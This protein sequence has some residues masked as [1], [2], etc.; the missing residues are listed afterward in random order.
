MAGVEGEEEG[1]LTVEVDGE[2]ASS[3][4]LR[5][6][7]EL[8][9]ATA[10]VVRSALLTVH[11]AGPEQVTFDMSEV[12]FMDSSGLSVLLEAAAKVSV[13]VAAP[14]A[15]VRRVIETT[16]LTDVLKVQQ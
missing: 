10:D 16:G 7:G 6:A 11:G 1:E 9:V 15:A 13:V 4:T 8:D 12:S 14:S 5:L 2:A 3:P